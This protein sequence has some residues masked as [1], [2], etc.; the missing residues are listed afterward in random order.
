MSDALH[1]EVSFDAAPSR[2]YQALMES[3]QHAEFTGGPADIGRKEGEA[4]S[5]HGGAILGRNIELV[6]NERIV[7]AWRVADWEAGVYSLI[8]IE[9]KSET[10]GTKLILDHDACPEGTG[11]HLDSGWHAR[12]WDPLRAYLA[13]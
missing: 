12:Y 5:C 8:R 11:E 13:G 9:L 10:G 1:Q 2:I 4:F 7:Q 6:E 3:T